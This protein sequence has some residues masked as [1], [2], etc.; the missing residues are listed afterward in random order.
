MY[1]Q[2]RPRHQLLRHQLL[3]HQLPQHPVQIAGG[4]SAWRLNPKWAK[5]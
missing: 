1:E 5:E 3:R 2:E 4:R